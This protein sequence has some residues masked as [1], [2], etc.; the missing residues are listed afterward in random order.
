[1]NC[2]T[3]LFMKC[4]GL[5]VAFVAGSVS[6]FS[7]PA[8]ARVM[9][10]GTVAIQLGKT[11]EVQT[12]S[13][14]LLS[15]NGQ[16]IYVDDDFEKLV[17]PITISGETIEKTRG[18]EGSIKAISS[19]EEQLQVSLDK[20]RVSFEDGKCVVQLT[21]KRLD[22]LEEKENDEVLGITLSGPSLSGPSLS[23]PNAM[24]DMGSETEDDKEGQ[25]LTSK[26]MFTYDEMTYSATIKLVD[27]EKNEDKTGDLSFCQSQYHPT[28][29]ITMIG[30]NES[31][32]EISGFPAMTK[33]ILED[34]TYVLYSGGSITIPTGKEIKIDLSEAKV[35]ED[36]LL[37]A[38]SGKTY[39]I[40]YAELPQITKAT[41]P[42]VIG[43]EGAILTEY[44]KW[45]IIEPVI[46]IE[47]LIIKDENPAWEAVENIKVEKNDKG[48]LQIMPNQAEAGTYRAVV[49]WNESEI[50]LEQ[51]EIPFFVQYT[52]VDQGG[53]GQ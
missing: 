21:M 6:C 41:F 1:M 34:Q 27:N 46:R 18:A 12:V 10:H 51:M 5:I 13:S 37:T 19:D 11:E 22:A 26:V 49:L 47:H 28:K 17:M 40:K 2:N 45:G 32:C 52:S 4:V 14:D 31:D 53:I 38:G 50:T 23:G 33:Y 48:K 24:P 20:N 29:L 7:A 15:E 9:N 3:K 25:E 39:T 8:T 44:E 16:T 36:L 42:T 30:G 35:K 43:E